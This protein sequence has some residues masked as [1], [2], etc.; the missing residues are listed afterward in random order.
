MALYH[1]SKGLRK[2]GVSGV[3]WRRC[4]SELSSDSVIKF[5]PPRKIH[6]TVFLLAELGLNRHRAYFNWLH[7]QLSSSIT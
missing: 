6:Q 7:N 1:T 3:D 2:P 4:L 5:R